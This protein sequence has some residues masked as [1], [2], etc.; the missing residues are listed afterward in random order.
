MGEE[1][2]VLKADPRIPQIRRKIVDPLTVKDDIPGA[3]FGE[4]ADDAQQRRLPA[5]A[6]PDECNQLSLMHFQG[7]PPE[8]LVFSIKLVDVLQNQHR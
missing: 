5:A 8:D 1:G 7:D 2:V 4:T 3:G 6:R